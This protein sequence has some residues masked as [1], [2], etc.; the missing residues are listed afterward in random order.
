MHEIFH[1]ID[2]PFQKI[3]K[4]KAQFIKV[5]DAIFFRIN[6][7]LYRVVFYMM[8]TVTVLLYPGVANFA[9]CAAMATSELA[10]S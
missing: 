3:L 1:A 10:T 9:D 5:D 7:L 8:F 6:I 2:R 4:E